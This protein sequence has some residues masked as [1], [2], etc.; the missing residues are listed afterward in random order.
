M[1][2]QKLLVH[3]CCAPCA[4][5]VIEELHNHFDLTLYAYN[6]CITDEAEWCMRFGEL[7]RLVKE[8]GYDNVELILADGDEPSRELFAWAEQYKDMPEGGKRCEMCYIQRL[9]ATAKY[10][11]QN[12]FK[13]FTTTLTLSP[14]KDSAYVNFVGRKCGGKM[15]VMYMPFDFG[16]LYFKSLELCKKYNLYQQDFC[17][18]EYSRQN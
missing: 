17:G 8:M 6:P 9:G 3:V 15:G 10:A 1:S 2:K 16:Y 13:Y 14:Y 4:S 11:K 7:R 5:A 12:G 18:C